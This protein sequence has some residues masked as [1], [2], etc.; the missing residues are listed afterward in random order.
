MITATE[1]KVLYDQS[2]AEVDSYLKHAVESKIV[3]AAMEG[4]RSVNI[5]LGSLDHFRHLDQEITPIQKAVVTKLKELKFTAEIQ[6]YGDQY[7]PRGLADDDG[8]GPSH[9]NYGFIIRW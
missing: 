7:V 8:N 5:H 2:G 3:K 9:R 1:A 4:K 6:L